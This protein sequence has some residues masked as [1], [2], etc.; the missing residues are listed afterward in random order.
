M[1]L[2]YLLIPAVLILLVYVCSELIK[3]YKNI[4]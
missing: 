2:N 3:L 1:L 4:K